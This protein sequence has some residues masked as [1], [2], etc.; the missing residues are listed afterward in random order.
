MIKITKILDPTIRRLFFSTTNYTMALVAS[1][2]FVGRRRAKTED[3]HRGPLPYGWYL[4]P[5]E[6]GPG[7]LVNLGRDAYV[8]FLSPT[9]KN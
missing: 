6:P 4:R 8:F 5:S 3:A 1:S 2:T 9:Y 7:R